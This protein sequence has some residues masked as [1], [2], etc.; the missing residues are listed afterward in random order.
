M[1]LRALVVDDSPIVRRLI[2]GFLR[3]EPG[4][5]VVAQAGS[6]VEAIALAREHRPDVITLDVEMPGMDGLETLRE[7]MCDV[8]TPIIMV[9]GVSNRAAEVTL[10]AIHA[11]AVDFVFKYTPATSRAPETVA[12]ELVAKVKAAARIKV[13]RSVR[14]TTIKPPGVGAD[15]LITALGADGDFDLPA[16]LAP[17]AAQRVRSGWEAKRAADPRTTALGKGPRLPAA[18]ANRIAPSSGDSAGHGAA[19]SGWSKWQTRPRVIAIGASTGGP[20]AVRELLQELPSDLP[21]AVLIVQHMP[22]AFTTVLAAQLGRSI[23]LPVCEATHGQLLVPGAVYVCPGDYH[24]LV[25]AD[26]RIE[27]GQE[28]KVQGYR[29]SVDVTMQCI[30]HLFGAQSIGV[31]LTGMGDDGAL[32]LSYIRARSGRTFAQSAES[33]VV[34]GMPQKAVDRGVV[35]AIGTPREIGQTLAK[36]GV[37]HAS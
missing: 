22:P 33:C 20:V 37:K 4:I 29:P 1:A 32:G 18:K 25:R 15:G 30:A 2:A 5:D 6:G 16:T 8:P 12:K 3:S 27:L 9:T 19:I 24:L 31:L 21:A 13:V 10:A 34:N 35:D 23:A 36:L 17:A 26:L 28:A 14:C 7:L 11:G